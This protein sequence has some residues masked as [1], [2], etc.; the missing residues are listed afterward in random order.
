[1]YY[2]FNVYFFNIIHISQSM[3]LKTYLQHA[4]TWDK[5]LRFFLA[6]LQVRHFTNVPTKDRKEVPVP[7]IQHH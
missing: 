1:M 3:N 6:L 4:K 2:L 5:K 7:S